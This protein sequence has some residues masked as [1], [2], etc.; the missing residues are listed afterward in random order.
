LLEIWPQVEGYA[1]THVWTGKLGISFDLMPHAGRLDGVWF[2]NGYCGHGIAIGSY[3]G[4]EIGQVI[5]GKRE[6]IPI[7]EIEQPRY[8]FSSLE[9]FFIP[10]VSWWYRF[11][12][13]RD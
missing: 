13:W 2:A 8:F 4:H 6:S 3:L 10:S 9:K 7:M 11:K 12:D 1:V 5:A